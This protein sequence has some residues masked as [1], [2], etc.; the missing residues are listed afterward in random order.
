MHGVVRKLGR[1][2]LHTQRR[3]SGWT[4]VDKA[5]CRSFLGS[6]VDTAAG[7]DG[8]AS[9]VNRRVFLVCD[10]ETLASSV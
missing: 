10:T 7:A 9:R 1:A 5:S 6:R 2:S 3:G 4:G 8:S